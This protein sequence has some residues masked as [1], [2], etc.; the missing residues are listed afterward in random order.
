MKLQSDVLNFLKL[1][2]YLDYKSEF[3][4]SDNIKL[5]NNESLNY[6]N[7]KNILLEIMSDKLRGVNSQEIVVPLSGGAD[8]RLLL[9][10]LSEFYSFSSINTFT[11]GTKGTLDYDIANDIGSN[12]GTKHHSIDLSSADFNIESLIYNSNKSHNQTMLFY[13]TPF[14]HI[15]ELYSKEALFFSGFMGDPSAGSKL[16]LN[17][18]GDVNKLFLNDNTISD[19]N[20]PYSKDT[21]SKLIYTKSIETLSEY[22][23]VDFFNR[24]AKYIMPHVMP[25]DDYFSPFLDERWLSLCFSL[26]ENM[27]INNKFY[28]EFCFNSFPELFSLPLKNYMGHTSKASKVKIFSKKVENKV[29]VKCSNFFG[30]HYV[31]NGMNYFDFS[32]KVNTNNEF[33]KLVM[34]LVG[35]ALNMLKKNFDEFQ[36]FTPKLLV[37]S[38]NYAHFCITLSS[39]GIQIIS[40]KETSNWF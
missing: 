8:S 5:L 1:G 20:I 37:E 39:L 14:H 10:L 17:L 23:T 25:S 24:Q 2:Y 30:L 13:S 35:V 3:N 7:A 15:D 32:L 36:S 11:F 26:P 38:P 34:Y 27:R 19:I 16:K 9:A 22:E 18:K 31:D 28:D 40:G 33:K 6:D 12:F 4:I 21:T 29:K